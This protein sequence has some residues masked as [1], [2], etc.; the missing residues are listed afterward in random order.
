[1]RCEEWVL[2]TSNTKKHARTH[3][4]RWCTDPTECGLS[5]DHICHFSASCC[6][7]VPWLKASINSWTS[8]QHFRAFCLLFV[9]FLAAN[10]WKRVPLL[11]L[12]SSRALV[13]VLNTPEKIWDTSVR[14][15]QP[16]TASREPK[17]FR[18]FWRRSIGFVRISPSPFEW[19][20]VWPI[21]DRSKKNLPVFTV[22]R[23]V[24]NTDKI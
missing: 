6:F 9:L 22:K 20:P 16:R 18:N 3:V 12:M 13:G 19:A 24:Q 15:G 2:G 7:V 1:M 4:T 8:H 14:S 5:N 17:N 10:I 23:G 21:L 11:K